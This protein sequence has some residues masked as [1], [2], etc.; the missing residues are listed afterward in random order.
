MPY[1]EKPKKFKKVKSLAKHINYYNC[2]AWTKLRLSYIV[3]FPLCQ[4]CL[5]KGRTSPVEQ[6]HHILPIH[7]S[8]DLLEQRNRA[9]DPE[10]LLSVCSECHVE[11]HNL[12]VLDPMI[13]RNLIKFMKN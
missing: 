3:E 11:L 4:L 8:E 12:L 7:G 9:Y 2:A 6:V 5:Y 13:Y 1:L 10:N